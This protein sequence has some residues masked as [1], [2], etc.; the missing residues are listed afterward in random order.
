MHHWCPES[1]VRRHTKSEPDTSPDPKSEEKERNAM[2]TKPVLGLAEVNE[3]LTAARA[4]AERHDWKVSIAVVDD[5]GHP[6]GL[7]RLDGAPPSSAY[8]A[9]EK[10]RTSSLGRRESKAY[11]DMINGG[12]YAFL[13][14]PLVATLEGAVPVLVNGHCVGAVGVSGVKSEQDAQIA[15]A[16][17]ARIAHLE[18]EPT[19]T[20]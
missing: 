2:Q 1:E 4:E 6:L 13:S 19:S 15:K 8:M 18:A 9:T 5:G 10:A 7:L 17:I 14:S 20:R 3:I 12:R 16:G 11:E